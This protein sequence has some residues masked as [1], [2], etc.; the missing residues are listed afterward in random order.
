MQALLVFGKEEIQ[1]RSDMDY[2]WSCRRVDVEFHVD[3]G[4]LVLHPP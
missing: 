3:L 4:E 2:D 1:V